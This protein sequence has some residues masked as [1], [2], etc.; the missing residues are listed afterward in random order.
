MTL[1]ILCFLIR[2]P[3]AVVGVHQR[4]GKRGFD[5][6]C[7][8]WRSREYSHW[9]GGHS[10]TAEGCGT[11]RRGCGEAEGCRAGWGYALTDDVG[12]FFLL[13]FFFYKFPPGTNLM[14]V[15]WAGAFIFFLAK[16]QAI[17]TCLRMCY[18]LIWVCTK[19][20]GSDSPPVLR[21]HE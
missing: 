5:P 17:E 11:F 8:V 21:S 7:P 9:G 1:F 6:H 13:L 3:A 4:P 20:C 18:G 14:S 12:F 16:L 15:S 10:R 2:I 19:C